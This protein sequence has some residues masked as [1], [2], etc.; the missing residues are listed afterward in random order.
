MLR[1]IHSEMQNCVI[2]QALKYKVWKKNVECLDHPLFRL[3]INSI[4]TKEKHLHC[5]E[6]EPFASQWTEN[7]CPTIC[8]PQAHFYLQ[9]CK[10]AGEAPLQ[11]QTCLGWQ[12][13]HPSGF[14]CK[15]LVSSAPFKR[16]PSGQNQDIY[17]LADG[18][19]YLTS[20]REDDLGSDRAEN[21]C[22]YTRSRNIVYMTTCVHTK[23]IMSS[24]WCLP[25]NPSPRGPLLSPPLASL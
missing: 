17:R 8:L 21:M 9:N 6:K 12:V 22:V 4:S 5:S 25:L 24:H 20:E 14:H 15:P 16:Q 3:E 7:T 2:F 18:G 13:L 1:W 11:S 10:T 23:I 19:S